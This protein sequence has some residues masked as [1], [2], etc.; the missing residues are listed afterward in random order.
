MNRP[1]THYWH[2]LSLLF[3]NITAVTNV[4]QI[5]SGITR[6]RVLSGGALYTEILEVER[7]LHEIIC[8]QMQIN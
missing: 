4:I 2:V 6:G 3:E 1:M 7:N 8:S 5:Y